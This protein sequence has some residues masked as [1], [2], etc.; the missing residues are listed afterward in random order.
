M[1]HYNTTQQL[2]SKAT[3][4]RSLNV[5]SDVV[6]PLLQSLITGGALA[7]IVVFVAWGIFGLAAGPSFAFGLALGVVAGWFWRMSVITETLWSI[8]E[9]AGVDLDGDDVIGR[10]RETIRLELPTPSGQRIF[11]LDGLG[12]DDLDRFARL[13]LSGRLN[14]RTIDALFGIGQADWN[15]MR[16]SLV[17]RDV[18]RWKGRPGTT[19]GVAL[20]D[21]GID[22]MTRIR[23]L[24]P[25]R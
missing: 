17:D 8:E 16:D 19:A 11:D 20:T 5:E 21:E 23:D 13:A 10:P 24:S 4:H 25:T 6:V 22:L 12:S 14:E 7:M 1:K 9:F 3:P 2:V 15:E 18:L